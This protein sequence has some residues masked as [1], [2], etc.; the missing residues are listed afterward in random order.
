MKGME[1]LFPVNMLIIWFM[2]IKSI[3]V[4]LFL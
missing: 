1:K 2:E 4:D 3:T